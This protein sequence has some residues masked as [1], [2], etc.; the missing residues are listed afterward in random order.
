MRL[1][2]AISFCS[3]A[4]VAEETVDVSGLPRPVERRVDFATEIQP[5]FDR[6]V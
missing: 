1:L 4:G 2:F 6:S 5:I 3:V